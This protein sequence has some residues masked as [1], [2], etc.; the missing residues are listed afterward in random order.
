MLLSFFTSCVVAAASPMP[1]PMP[2][3]TEAA[4]FKAAFEKG[5]AQYSA[6]DYGPAI[7]NFKLADSQRATPE[8]AYDLAKSFEKL[9]D[10]AFTLLYYRLYLRRAPEASDTLEIAAKVGQAI[11]AAERDGRGFLEAWV[12]LAGAVTVRSAAGAVWRFAESPVALTLPPGQYDIEIGLGPGKK[13]MRAEVRV[14]RAT[15]VSFEP[16]R[17]PMVAV[18]G[19]LTEALSGAGLKGDQQAP[20]VNRVRVASYVIGGVGA[21][22]LIAGIVL[23]AASNGDA[24]QARDK[25]STAS[26]A[27]SAATS[28]NGKGIAA[29][30]LFGTGG[31]VLA[32]ATLLFVF[33]MPEPGMEQKR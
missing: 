32:G 20:S 14:G 1:V 25:T 22:A 13:K 4:R 19:A 3:E 29:N 5:E 6:G 8:V 21:A 27:Q 16:V 33:S 12:P 15:M 26:S 17:P 24:A 23:G 30:V 18:E 28:A 11:G 31:A 7:Y 9:S 2:G 10:T